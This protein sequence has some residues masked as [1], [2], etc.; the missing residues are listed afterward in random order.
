MTRKYRG[1][2]RIALLRPRLLALQ[3]LAVE[4][5]DGWDTTVQQ[6]REWFAAV[7]SFARDVAAS[8]FSTLEREWR[9]PSTSRQK[10]AHR[11]G[12]YVGREADWMR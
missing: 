9:K 4:R 5:G 3:A 11:R 2:Q 8:P 10:K 6:D 12:L 1:A 7:D